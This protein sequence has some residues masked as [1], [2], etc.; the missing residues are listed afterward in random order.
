M[1]LNNPVAFLAKKL[2]NAEVVYRRLSE[3]DKKL[4]TNA[5][6]A[7]VSSFLKTAAVRRCLSHEENLQAQNSGRVLKARWVLVWKAIPGEDRSKALDLRAADP[8]NTTVNADGTQKAKARIVVLGFQH[9]DLASTTFRSSAPVQSQLMRNLALFVTSQ[10]NWVLESLDMSTA[11]LQTGAQ[12]MEEEKLY[13]S[14]V[15]ELKQALGASDAELLRLVKNI[16]G[17]STAPR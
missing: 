16:Y 10:R 7:E 6:A 17:N 14:G 9:P 12:Q 11:F 3:E 15:P 13:T 8:D 2:N 1:F 4:F 5:K